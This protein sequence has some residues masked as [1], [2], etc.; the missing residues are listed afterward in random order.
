MA[1]DTNS[2]VHATT[3]TSNECFFFLCA[4]WKMTTVIDTGSNTPCT[5]DCEVSIINT[6]A[7]FTD[8]SVLQRI[9]FVNWWPTV[10]RT[11][12]ASLFHSE[13][14]TR[15]SAI[16]VLYPV[17]HQFP[18][19]DVPSNRMAM[20]EL[21]A[22]YNLYSS[23]LMFE[24]QHIRNT[25]QRWTQIIDTMIDRGEKIMKTY[26]E[27]S[28]SLA[29]KATEIA[30]TYGT[31]NADAVSVIKNELHLFGSRMKRER[32]LELQVVR[33][34][35]LGMEGTSRPETRQLDAKISEMIREYQQK[36]P[37][38]TLETL[39]IM[40]NAHISNIENEMCVKLQRDH[41]PKWLRYLR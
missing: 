25:M 34:E 26:S 35:T 14:T 37:K 22:L 16:Q 32:D 21:N 30:A 38:Q 3:P 1:R 28:N 27:R 40:Y 5:N 11:L 9:Q 13:K 4:P 10:A 33:A 39:N 36:Y 18:K 20:T 7:Q 29:T 15:R 8:A 24:E 12:V 41:V 17:L 19:V 6:N 2:Y 31:D 23:R